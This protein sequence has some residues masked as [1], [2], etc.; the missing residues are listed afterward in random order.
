MSV[1]LSALNF[2]Y[3]CKSPKIRLRARIITYLILYF[4]SNSFKSSFLC[5]TT[6]NTINII[7]TVRLYEALFY[8][9]V[10]LLNYLFYSL[11]P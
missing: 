1:S 6:E 11:L 8:F 3:R 2:V 9:E 7:V 4:T 10:F 5:L